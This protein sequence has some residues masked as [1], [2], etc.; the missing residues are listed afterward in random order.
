MLIQSHKMRI[1]T[2]FSL[3]SR[4]SY[5]CGLALDHIFNLLHHKHTDGTLRGV[6]GT[7]HLLHSHTNKLN[8]QITLWITY[9]LIYGL[10]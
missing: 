8:K 7:H 2:A 5:L 1:G 10:K 9:N 3:L 4:I 6:T